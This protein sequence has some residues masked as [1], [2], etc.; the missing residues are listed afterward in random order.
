M[1]WSHTNV[2]RSLHTYSFRCKLNSLSPASRFSC[3]NF[4]PQTAI[5]VSFFQPRTP[6]SASHI[7]PNFLVGEVGNL[8]VGWESPSETCLL[9]AIKSRSC[10]NSCGKFGVFGLPFLERAL[11]SFWQNFINLS[12]HRTLWQVVS[13]V[14]PPKKEKKEKRNK[15][16]QQSLISLA[17]INI[18]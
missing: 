17:A 7:W 12:R 15:R 10:P 5:F 8:K 18:L 4:N 3:I 6:M 13:E 14:K 2:L 1:D 9:F 16:P 11:L